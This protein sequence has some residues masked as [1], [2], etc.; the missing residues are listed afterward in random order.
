MKYLI[1]TAGW[2]MQVEGDSPLSA[3][4]KALQKGRPRELGQ[5]MKAK[6]EHGRATYLSTKVVVERSGVEYKQS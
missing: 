3:A 4:I 5:I 2:E 6:P 1:T